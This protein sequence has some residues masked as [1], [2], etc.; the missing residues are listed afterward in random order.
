MDL[1]RRGK[2]LDP[3]NTKETTLIQLIITKSKPFSKDRVKQTR[4]KET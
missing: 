2:K 4:E 3:T 1:E